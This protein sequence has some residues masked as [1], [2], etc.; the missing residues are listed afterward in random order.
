L[1]QLP[2]WNPA[3][4]VRF[5][6]IPLSNSFSSII[7]HRLVYLT[8]LLLTSKNI[9]HTPITLSRRTQGSSKTT[10]ARL[11][12]TYRSP[13]D[14]Q[15]SEAKKVIYEERKVTHA[16]KNLQQNPTKDV[17]EWNGGGKAL[18]VLWHAKMVTPRDRFSII[19]KHDIL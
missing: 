16:L 14:V 3:F 4:L 2:R 5:A 6:E 9:S 15:I 19:S 17:K 10:Y 7:I 11:E 12:K 8:F 1:L 18:L 13:L